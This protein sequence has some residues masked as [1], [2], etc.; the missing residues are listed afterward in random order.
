MAPYTTPTI[1]NPR[2]RPFLLPN[3][4]VLVR[5]PPRAKHKEFRLALNGWLYCVAV[6][7]MSGYKRNEADIT[8]L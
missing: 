2:F 7:I 5:P 6:K 1:P 8:H 4:A 3:S